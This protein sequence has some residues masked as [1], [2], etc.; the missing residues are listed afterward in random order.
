MSYQQHVCIFLDGF[1]LKRHFLFEFSKQEKRFL[2]ILNY[3][4]RFYTWNYTQ[5]NTKTTQKYLQFGS[6]EER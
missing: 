5:N 3:F 4:R 6:T 2:I 1:T